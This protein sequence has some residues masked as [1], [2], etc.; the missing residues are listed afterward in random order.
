MPEW[1]RN[2]PRN[3]FKQTLASCQRQIGLWSGL[4]SPIVAEIIAGA[5]FDWIV[6]DGE[7]APK[8][9]AIPSRATAGHA[10]RHR[11]AGLPRAME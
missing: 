5:G 11:R 8:R 7:H 1:P 10:R 2:F 4:C 6:I 3:A 9:Y